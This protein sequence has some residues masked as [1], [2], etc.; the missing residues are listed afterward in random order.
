MRGIVVLALGCASAR[1]AIGNSASWGPGADSGGATAGP[2]PP[3]S[4]SVAFSIPV[5]GAGARFA[6][7]TWVAIT[8]LAARRFASSRSA[9]KRARAPRQSVN[10]CPA[11]KANA[12]RVRSQRSSLPKEKA[13][14]R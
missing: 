1:S 13:V 8:G 7:N 12:K 3:V 5:L 6:G 9:R 14:D 11:A 10:R 4:S 2:G